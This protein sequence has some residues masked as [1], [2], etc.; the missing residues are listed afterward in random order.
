MGI[1]LT[2]GG[3]IGFD[4]DMI[5]RSQYFIGFALTGIRVPS[6]ILIQFL[7]SKISKPIQGYEIQPYWGIR[8]GFVLGPEGS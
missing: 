6:G 4:L 2:A 1:R 5:G 7:H 3:S 8:L